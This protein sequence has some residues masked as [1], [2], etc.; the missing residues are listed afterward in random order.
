MVYWAHYDQPISDSASFW[1]FSS[2]SSV[3]SGGNALEPAMTALVFK[4]SFS[5]AGQ[6]GGWYWIADAAKLFHGLWLVC[7]H[8]ILVYSGW[9]GSH[10][11][12]VQYVHYS[13][14][15][16]SLWCS[17][18]NWVTLFIGG[19]RGGW[20]EHSTCCTSFIVGRV[21]LQFMLWSQCFLIRSICCR[22]SSK[23][24]SIVTKLTKGCC[25]W[26]MQL[27]YWAENLI[28]VSTHSHEI[29]NARLQHIFRYSPA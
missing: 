3:G 19:R 1:R 2:V 7:H 18:K 26:V 21:W 8:I 20:V 10:S 24:M 27:H 15:T 12:A 23:Y 9:N 29:W 6:S 22:E 25:R 5:I 14:I 28:Q 13:A 11:F 17:I 4:A 16:F